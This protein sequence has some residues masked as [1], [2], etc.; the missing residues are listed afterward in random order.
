[1]YSILLLG[2]LIS[3]STLPLRAKNASQAISFVDGLSSRCSF[4]LR[5]GLASIVLRSQG[6]QERQEDKKD[7]TGIHVKKYSIQS[8]DIYRVELVED[9]ASKIFDLMASIDSISFVDSPITILL[10]ISS[11]TSMNSTKQPHMFECS[12]ALTQ[13]AKSMRFYSTPEAISFGSSSRQANR[14]FPRYAEL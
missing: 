6:R 2:F 1:M 5:G 9:P 8:H 7:K 3:V 14:I 13:Q 11:K 4:C 12:F 10:E